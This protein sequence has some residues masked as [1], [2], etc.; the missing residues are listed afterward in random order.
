MVTGLGF[1]FDD[2]YLEPVT[3][4]Q[5]IERMLRNIILFLEKKQETYRIE[6][7][8]QYIDSLNSNV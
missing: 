1:T 7:I 5:I 6:T 4:A 2:A 8:R 3:N